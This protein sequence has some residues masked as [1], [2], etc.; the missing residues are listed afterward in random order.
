MSGPYLPKGDGLR[1]GS[2]RLRTLRTRVV[3]LGA[4]GLRNAVRLVGAGAGTSL[5]GLFLERWDPTF[6]KDVA[7]TAQATVI[8]VSGTNGKTTTASMIRHILRSTGATVAGNEGGSNMTRGIWTTFLDVTPSTDYIVL[9]VDEAVAPQVVAALQP[10]LLLLTNVFRDQLDRF[11][12]AERVARLLGQSAEL[13]Q[14]SAD[15]LVNI[16]D[17]SLSWAVRDR[18]GPVTGFGADAMPGQSFDTASNEPE[19]CPRCGHDLS[20]TSRTIG[21][22]GAADCHHCGWSC[23]RGGT[24]AQVLKAYGLDGIEIGIEDSAA[25]LAIGGIHAAYNA[26]AAVTAAKILGVTVVDACR[27]LE[28]FVPRFGRDEV[29][30]LAGRRVHVLLMKNPVGANAVFGQACS[31]PRLGCAVVAVNDRTADGRDVSWIWDTD[32][33]LLARAGVPLIPSG[34]RSEDVALRIK[35]A[36]GTPEPAEPNVARAIRGAAASCA[37]GQEAIVF[38][39]YTAMLELRRGLTEGRRH[40][41]VE[42]LR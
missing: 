15:L 14:E 11:G 9:E 1:S 7:A 29:L 4:R 2:R 35:Y 41:R 38:A 25:R 21:Q 6:L 31:D 30:E 8:A 17:P 42:A 13:L 27:S 16:D 36:G 28:G 37:E 22:L 3:R 23:G 32:F 40:R 33:E 12:E 39:T 5:P 10:H 20:Y 24:R 34:R 19:I 18:R 26:A